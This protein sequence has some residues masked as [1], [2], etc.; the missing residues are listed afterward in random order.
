[1][2]CKDSFPHMLHLVNY[3]SHQ[4][5]CVSFALTI[6]CH[7]ERKMKIT[8]KFRKHRWK[9]ETFTIIV[10]NH[11]KI[12]LYNCAEK[13]F[14]RK[15]MNNFLISLSDIQLFM[16]IKLQYTRQYWFYTYWNN[17]NS[18]LLWQFGKSLWRCWKFHQGLS[19]SKI[20]HGI[21]KKFIAT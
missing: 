6:L 10:Q 20:S 3:Q 18:T 7:C 16:I 8:N 15:F 4:S 12:H 2:P 11:K 1:M 9:S 13:M 14:A 17:S 5:A 19:L 21:S